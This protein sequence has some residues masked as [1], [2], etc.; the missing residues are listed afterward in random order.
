M[1]TSSWRVH[2]FEV[3]FRANQSLIN[4]D[5]SGALKYGHL[6]HFPYYHPD[7]VEVQ[8][9]LEEAYHGT[10]RYFCFPN[11]MRTSMVLASDNE[12]N[13]HEVLVFIA[14]PT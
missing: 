1:V 4:K 11:M 7:N 12:E 14:H 8:W 3:P 13:G 10:W 2:H 9:D 5:W 6:H